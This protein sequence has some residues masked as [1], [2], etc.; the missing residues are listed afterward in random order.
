MKMGPQTQDDQL[1]HRFGIPYRHL[2]RVIKQMIEEG[3]VKEKGESI[4]F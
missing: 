3:L 4:R 2:N 1:A